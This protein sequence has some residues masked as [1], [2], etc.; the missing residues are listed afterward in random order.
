M[1]M[2]KSDVIFEQIE[3]ALVTKGE[4]MVK[5][6]KAVFAFKVQGGE[7]WIVDLKNDKGKVS[8]GEGKADCTIQIADDDLV[9]MASGKLD[10]MQAF[11]SGKMK[12]Q[13]NMML[14][15]K[16]QGIFGELEGK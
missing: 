2:G 1:G 6:I 12:I 8:K 9:A 15:Q 4:E 13:G 16:L 5:Q 14:A 7:N 3:K 10:G 11:M